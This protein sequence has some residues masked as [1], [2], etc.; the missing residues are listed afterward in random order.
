MGFLVLVRQ[1][2]PSFLDELKG[3]LSESEPVLAGF[4]EG[5]EFLELGPDEC[6]VF[7]A[8][9]RYLENG[10]PVSWVLVIGG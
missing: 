5:L 9:S 3:L 10:A 7:R 6:R 1:E 4:Q 2:G 8:G